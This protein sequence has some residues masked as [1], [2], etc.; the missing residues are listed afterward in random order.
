[1]PEEQ[2]YREFYNYLCKMGDDLHYRKKCAW[3]DGD[4]GDFTVISAQHNKVEEIIKR[5]QEVFE[6]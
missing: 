1:M 2:T 5:Y 3:R 6:L 4:L